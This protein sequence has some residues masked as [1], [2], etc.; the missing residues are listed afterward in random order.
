M[1]H[2]PFLKKNLHF[3]GKIKEKVLFGC[4]KIIP[5]LCDVPQSGGTTVTI[6]TDGDR[7]DSNMP[8]PFPLT[9]VYSTITTFTLVNED[10]IWIIFHTAKYLHTFLLTPPLWITSL[11]TT[12]LWITSP[13]IIWLC[14]HSNM[15]PQEGF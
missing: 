6:I 1:G 5:Y 7:V 13:Y 3:I 9:K 14:P 8:S 2:I 15:T 11:M 4:L 12:C 10:T